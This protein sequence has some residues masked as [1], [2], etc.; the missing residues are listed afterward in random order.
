[1]VDESDGELN[2][3]DSPGVTLE[4]AHLD[5]MGPVDDD[6]RDTV[7]GYHPRW[8]PATKAYALPRKKKKTGTH[9]PPQTPKRT[10]VTRSATPPSPPKKV[11]PK[12]RSPRDIQNCKT[13]EA[14]EPNAQVIDDLWLSDD[15]DENTDEK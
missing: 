12:R 7:E 9:Q 15:S 8:S 6:S 10:P 11:T 5:D 3:E 14:E 2:L 4:E 13:F 1:M